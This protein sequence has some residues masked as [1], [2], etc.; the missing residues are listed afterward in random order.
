MALLA[1]RSTSLENSNSYSPT[2]LL[3]SRRLHSSL[4]L[5]LEQLPSH[6]DT[7]KVQEEKI[8]DEKWISTL[9]NLLKHWNHSY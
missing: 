7:L 3:M 9:V 5:V 1:Y 2:K 6:L 4:P 8:A